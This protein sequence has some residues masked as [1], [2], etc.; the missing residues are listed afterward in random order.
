VLLSGSPYGWPYQ[1]VH[2][3]G[4]YTNT[5]PVHLLGTQALTSSRQLSKLQDLGAFLLSLVNAVHY[6]ILH[7]Q[8]IR[9]T[10][11]YDLEAKITHFLT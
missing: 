8:L 6:V 3:F 4:H 10:L 5:L 1:T 2:R 7:S 11:G 9:P